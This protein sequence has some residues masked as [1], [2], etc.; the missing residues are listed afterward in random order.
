LPVRR[1]GDIPEEDRH[2]GGRLVDKER[3][4]QGQPPNDRP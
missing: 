1:D 4:G 3:T 2:L